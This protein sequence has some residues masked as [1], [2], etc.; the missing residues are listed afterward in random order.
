MIKFII[1]SV[2]TT[3]FL[4]L[5]ISFMDLEYLNQYGWTFFIIQ[6]LVFLYGI[7]GVSKNVLIYFSPSVFT[8]IYLNLNFG[9][10]QWAVAN[11]ISYETMYYY[12]YIKFS[13]PHF[14]IIYLLIC[15]LAVA[16]AIIPFLKSSITLDLTALLNKSASNKSQ[17][18]ISLVFILL[19][20]LVEVDLSFLGG[21]GNFN[22]PLQL[23]ATIF[24]TIKL[25]PFPRL[26]RYLYYA[27][28]SI[29]FLVS[30]YN[31]KR[32]ILFIIILFLLF[33]LNRTSIKVEL[34]LKNSLLGVLF[35]TSFTGFI[36]V[37]SIARGYGNFNVESPLD[38]V[39][40]ID[41]YVQADYFQSVVVGNLEVITVYG[42]TANAINF[43]Y[44]E[45]IGLGYGSTFAKALFIPIPRFIFPDKPRS[46][47]D[48]YTSKFQPSYRVEKGGSLPVTIYG[49]IFY[50]FNLFGIIF[51][52]L[53]FLVLNRMFQKMVSSLSEAKISFHTYIFIF[54]YI[55]L[56]QFV[57]GSGLD[58]W[59][60]YAL[61][62]CLVFVPVSLIKKTKPY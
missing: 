3:L 37:S 36:L 38:A 11:N 14:I 12:E 4:V 44:N 48:I 2:L 9:F 24:L 58:L 45:E 49:E 50:N 43:T 25:V 30:N 8:L 32:E 51:L 18:F 1:I 35:I 23:A 20:S 29:L 5:A 40:Y 55:T 41:D 22:Y 21:V 16:L 56:I 42:N 26:V 62:S 46:M 57:R 47:I 60:L 33:E 59:F 52:F 17:I 6:L 28:L 7:N 31:S 15:S 54:L 39:E 27:I 13:N 19:L 53:I 10:G 61:I 34:N